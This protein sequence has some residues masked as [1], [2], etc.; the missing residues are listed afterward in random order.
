[1]PSG[2]LSVTNDGWPFNPVLST[3]VICEVDDPG[4]EADYFVGFLYNNTTGDSFI[5]TAKHCITSDDNVIYPRFRSMSDARAL[6]RK[7]LAL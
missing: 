1:M 7:R 2:R 5:I 3:T 4:P 6:P